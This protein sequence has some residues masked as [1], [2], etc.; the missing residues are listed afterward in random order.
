MG[1]PQLFHVLRRGW[2]SCTVGSRG[3]VAQARGENVCECADVPDAITNAAAYGEHQIQRYVIEANGSSKKRCAL[4]LQCWGVPSRYVTPT[5]R[6]NTATDFTAGGKA[7]VR[8]QMRLANSARTLAVHIDHRNKLSEHATLLPGPR[9]QNCQSVTHNTNAL[10]YTNAFPDASCIRRSNAM[11]TSDGKTEAAQ[12]SSAQ[13]VAAHHAALPHVVFATKSAPAMVRSATPTQRLGSE[14][15][16]SFWT[17]AAQHRK[18]LSKQTSRL[19]S[20]THWR[21]RRRFH[22]KRILVCPPPSIN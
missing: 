5:T 3:C 19:P 2:T 17:G 1:G 14:A 16:I 6:T 18:P 12:H 11:C 15:S 21:S 4:L 13:T 22:S 7:C 10:R 9:A 8:M 20:A